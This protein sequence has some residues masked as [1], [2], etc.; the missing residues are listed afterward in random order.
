MLLLLS[1]YNV[2]IC[3]VYTMLS[4]LFIYNPITIIY[5]Q[6]YYLLCVQNAIIIVYTMLSLLFVYNLVTIICIQC[7]YFAMCTQSYYYYVYTMLLLLFVYNFATV[8]C[9]YNLIIVICTHRYQSIVIIN[10]WYDSTWYGNWI[11]IAFHE[12]Q[13]ASYLA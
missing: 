1:T 13:S 12:V 10:N 5:I 8:I 4:L 9:I 3:Y 2:T 7:Y 6:C 11:S